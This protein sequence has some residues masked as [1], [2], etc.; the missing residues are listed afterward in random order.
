M[1]FTEYHEGL[2]YAGVIHEIFV[3]NMLFM[4]M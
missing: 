4:F 2:I 3:E 1:T